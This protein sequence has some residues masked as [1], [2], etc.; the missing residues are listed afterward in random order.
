MPGR[1]HDAVILGI[2]I[3]R[4]RMAFAAPGPIIDRVA[5][6]ASRLGPA[7]AG[8]EH[9]QCRI[10]GKQLVRRQ[11]GAADQHTAASATSM[12]DLPSCSTWIGPASRPGGPASAIGDTAEGRHRTCSPPH[13]RSAPRS[14]CRHRS[15]AASDPPPTPNRRASGDA[16]QYCR[17]R[18]RC[19]YRARLLTGA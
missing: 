2:H 19:R 11:H 9:R 18:A 3:R 15:A 8:I 12:H 10:G 14:P 1:A 4:G 16:A 5:P 17:R 7:A 6:Q 13:A